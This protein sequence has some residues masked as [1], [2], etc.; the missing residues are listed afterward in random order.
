[1]VAEVKWFEH[2][3]A[4]DLTDGFAIEVPERGWTTELSTDPTKLEPALTD[5]DEY[6]GLHIVKVG[7]D[8]DGT[9]RVYILDPKNP[10]VNDSRLKNPDEKT[11][12]AILKT[13]N[14]FA[15]DKPDPKYPNNRQADSTDHLG[16]YMAAGAVYVYESHPV[17]TNFCP[18]G[19]EGAQDSRARVPG[20]ESLGAG[21]AVLLGGLLNN[22]S[23]QF[24]T[25]EPDKNYKRELRIKP[26]A[27]ADA[28][29]GFIKGIKD[30]VQ[31][32]QLDAKVA[33]QFISGVYKNFV[34]AP[35]QQLVSQ[36]TLVF[37]DLTPKE[38]DRITAKLPGVNWILLDGKPEEGDVKKL[39]LP[40][41]NFNPTMLE[42]GERLDE[43]L[44]DEGGF[45]ADGCEEVTWWKLWTLPN[46]LSDDD[47]RACSLHHSLDYYLTPMRHQRL[48]MVYTIAIQVGAIILSTLG[49]AYFLSPD[50][51]KAMQQKFHNVAR[52][53]ENVLRKITGKDL[54]KTNPMEELQ[55]DLDVKMV[56]L[57]E[58]AR[59]YL[60]D[61]E[62]FRKKYDKGIPGL[63]VP[64]P[65]LEDVPENLSEDEDKEDIEKIRTSMEKPENASAWLVGP[66]GDGK[67]YTALKFILR[68]ARGDFGEKW[69]TADF[70]NFSKSI[71][72]GQKNQNYSSGVKGGTERLATAITKALSESKGEAILFGDEVHQLATAGEYYEN[73]SKIGGSIVESFL[74]QAA[75][76]NT[77]RMLGTSTTDEFADA[78]DHQKAFFGSSGRGTRLDRKPKTE[79]QVLS[80][81]EKKKKQ[82]EKE[83]KI[84]I[85]DDILKPVAQ[86]SYDELGLYN[87]RAVRNKLDYIVRTKLRET[88]V[89]GFKITPDDVKRLAD[90]EAD[91]RLDRTVT[92]AFPA[93]GKEIEARKP[94]QLELETIKLVLSEKFPDFEKWEPATQVRMVNGIVK[95]WDRNSVIRARFKREHGRQGFEFYVRKA[96]ENQ[97]V[98]DRSQEAQDNFLA[99]QEIQ[100]RRA[101]NGAQQADATAPKNGE[102]TIEQAEEIFEKA[103]GKGWGEKW[104]AR[105]SLSGDTVEDLMTE[106]FQDAYNAYKKKRGDKA[107]SPEKYLE[108]F[109]IDQKLTEPAR[110]AAQPEAPAQQAPAP[111]AATPFEK[112]AEESR[113]VVAEVASLYKGITVSDEVV[114][115]WLDMVEG[116]DIPEKGQEKFFERKLGVFKFLVKEAVK[117][118]TSGEVTWKDFKEARSAYLK[119][120]REI[121]EFVTKNPSRK[122]SE[123]D[124]VMEYYEKGAGKTPKEYFDGLEKGNKSEVAEA[125]ADLKPVRVDTSADVRDTRISRAE[126]IEMVY[127]VYGRGMV[128][129]LKLDEKSIEK[130][131]DLK[132]AVKEVLGDE[133]W[134]ELQ[135]RIANWKTTGNLTVA[136]EAGLYLEAI[137]IER[138][139]GQFEVDQGM[140]RF[141]EYERKVAE[142]L[143][144]RSGA[145]RKKSEEEVKREKR[146]YEE[147]LKEPLK[148]RGK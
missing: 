5:T 47:A 138:N 55:R 129:A 127:D 3:Q 42:P 69:K 133:K 117:K 122:G 84:T 23:D 4:D 136:Q 71:V 13:T 79:T 116:D 101:P 66:P 126:M 106:R 59:E 99:L 54:R 68:A 67:T 131:E 128:E 145:E 105:G 108:R 93:D 141:A 72:E 63:D 48:Q 24:C 60:K 112:F 98:Q 45:S 146:M 14:N 91:E 80:V 114:T 70:W 125:L 140:K 96:L 74:T 11:W 36:H 87:S 102:F 8:E 12:R 61:P 32:G 94:T 137:H 139:G 147:I 56:D 46:A 38:A 111:K 34:E 58:L 9:R 88:G 143:E 27:S 95:V 90:K 115:R 75:G 41:P 82:L 29:K 83:L 113:K 28:A 64:W 7:R 109:W 89:D 53:V 16:I 120:L 57:S 144:K 31:K 134:A 76:S 81:L 104:G 50:A 25:T 1:M 78:E 26:F 51:K 103:Y 92:D 107:L 43:W 18:E 123:A 52:R 22:Q 135:K 86:A 44:I 77:F 85:P 130:L 148:G 121:S 19:R 110:L 37:K 100:A 73:H 6:K 97:T 142:K 40:N 33:E 132:P 10:L 39:Y 65:D 62:A 49:T 119:V 17:L 124:L 118:V 2:E 15:F 20:F 35:D 30:L 21:E